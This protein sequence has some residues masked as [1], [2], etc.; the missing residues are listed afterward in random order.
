[1]TEIS[2]AADVPPRLTD[3]EN[4]RATFRIEVPERFNAVI[5]IFERWADGAAALLLRA[6]AHRNGAVLA[7]PPP[8]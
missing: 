2:A 1:M 8:R 6:R 7:R 3:Y 4:E 5:D